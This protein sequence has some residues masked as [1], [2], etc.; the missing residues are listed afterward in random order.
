M[1]WQLATSLGL[2]AWKAYEAYKFAKDPVGYSQSHGL[3]GDPPI[4]FG[5]RK[6]QK[7]SKPLWTGSKLEKK[8]FKKL[9]KDTDEMPSYGRKTRKRGGKG[10][11]YQGKRVPGRNGY[12]KRGSAPGIKTYKKKV[13]TKSAKRGG[14]SRLF[15]MVAPPLTIYNREFVPRQLT[16]EGEM[17][18]SNVYQ[19]VITP[20]VPA[21]PENPGDPNADPPIPP[22][23]GSDAVPAVTE[24]RLSD[25]IGRS[26]YYPNWAMFPI[27]TTREALTYVI[28]CIN[29]PHSIAWDSHHHPSN[30][31]THTEMSDIPLEDR[32]HGGLSGDVNTDVLIPS[33]VSFSNLYGTIEG[34][35]MSYTLTNSNECSV[36]VE[37]YE[38]RPRDPIDGIDVPLTTTGNSLVEPIVKPENSSYMNVNINPLALI[39]YD[40]NRKKALAQAKYANGMADERYPKGV[41]LDQSEDD[42]K[43]TKDIKSCKE[44]NKHYVVLQSKRVCMKPGERFQYD[45]VIPG[46]GVR[47]DKYLKSAMGYKHNNDELYVPLAELQSTFT[48]F[49]LVKHRSVRMFKLQQQT[50]TD[51]IISPTWPIDGKGAYLRDCAITVRASKYIR[52]RLLPR[53]ERSI[54]LRTSADNDIDWYGKMPKYQKDTDLSSHNV[55]SWNGRNLYQINRYPNLQMITGIGNT[56]ASTVTVNPTSMDT[57]N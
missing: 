52:A 8:G 23:P 2:G 15:D 28:K 55:G 50:Q 46:F 39:E 7:T 24:D 27:L 31:F 41:P 29:T 11:V 40:F 20:A 17:D 43:F 3:L 42:W 22:T 47:F 16:K 13:K 25:I 57:G 14:A 38:V 12:I 45:V 33:S 32:D 34:F 5:S 49:L 6:K 1:S 35:K 54:K 10:G 26:D 30:G 21:I 9:Y 37:I 51:G 48:R 18:D 19:H 44:F 53:T 36:W 56:S 4:T